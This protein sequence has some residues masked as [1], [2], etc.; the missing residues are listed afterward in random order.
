MDDLGRSTGLELAEALANDDVARVE[1]DGHCSVAYEQAVQ[2]EARRMLPPCD[3]P[4]PPPEWW[5]R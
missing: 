2:I 3:S 1:K 4:G 5:S